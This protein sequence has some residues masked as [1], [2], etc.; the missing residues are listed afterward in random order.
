MHVLGELS[1]FFFKKDHV[2]WERTIDE[3]VVGRVEGG[4]RSRF[5]QN[6]LTVYMKF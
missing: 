5:G 6:T 2:I 4:L 1:G 3:R